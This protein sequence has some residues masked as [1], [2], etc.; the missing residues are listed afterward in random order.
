LWRN[1]A[2]QR[3]NATAQ[4]NGATAQRRN[5]AT[6]QRNGATAQRRNGATAQRRNL[7]TAQNAPSNMLGATGLLGYGALTGFNICKGPLC[8]A[9]FDCLK[10]ETA[11]FNSC[12]YTFGTKA[13]PKGV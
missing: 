9:S 3:R 8:V 7:A 11:G 2:T 13:C 6:A 4:R 1:G 5:G 12:H 10:I